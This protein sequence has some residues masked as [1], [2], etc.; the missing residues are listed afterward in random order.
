MAGATPAVGV[1]LGVA[2]HHGEVLAVAEDTR[3]VAGVGG[4]IQGMAAAVGFT[5][6]DRRNRLGSKQIAVKGLS[7]LRE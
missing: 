1:V 5:M 6:P 2:V 4:P 3:V 7:P